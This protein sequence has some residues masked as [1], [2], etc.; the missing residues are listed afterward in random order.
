VVARLGEQAGGAAV[1]GALVDA[2][3]AADKGAP[4]GPAGGALG[5]PHR[6]RG[7]QKADRDGQPH[8]GNHQVVNELA[9]GDA[10]AWGAEAEVE[11]DVLPEVLGH[12][13]V[14]AQGLLRAG[15]G[16]HHADPGEA[17]EGEAPP[18]PA[19]LEQD[20]RL[21]GQPS[22]DGQGREPD[23]HQQDQQ[24][25]VGGRLPGRPGDRLAGG[26]LPA[27]TRRGVVGARHE[28]PPAVERR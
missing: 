27:V 17:G 11:G 4:L 6:Q 23:Q 24:Q 3:A 18:V 20:H 28:A 9:D 16:Q 14:P 19:A 22:H 15:H 1:A 26:G 5:G 7:G 13:D 25:P 2:L 21:P 10:G 8:L 12:E